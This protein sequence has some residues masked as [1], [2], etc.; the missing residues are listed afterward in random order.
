VNTGVEYGRKAAK[1]VNGELLFPDFSQ[2]GNPPGMTDFN[3]FINA[4]GVL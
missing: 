1:A 2:W 3:D 4:G